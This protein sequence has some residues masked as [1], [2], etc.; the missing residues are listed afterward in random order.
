MTST[1]IEEMSM[2]Y[3]T[4]RLELIRSLLL[5]GNIGVLL[6]NRGTVKELI[7]NYRTFRNNPEYNP[8]LP[9]FLEVVLEIN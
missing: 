7:N 8:S 1:I 5:D 9:N 2:G 3:Y 6:R 4:E